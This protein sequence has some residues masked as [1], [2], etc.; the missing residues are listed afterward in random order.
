[1]WL[2]SRNDVAWFACSRGPNEQFSRGDT[3]VRTYG[4][5]RVDPEIFNINSHFQFSLVYFG[6]TDIK[7]RNY[8]AW[9][10]DIIIVGTILESKCIYKSENIQKSALNCFKNYL[11]KQSHLRP[12]GLDNILD[13]S[14]SGR[15]KATIWTDSL[16]AGVWFQFDQLLVCW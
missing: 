14:I 8:M 11:N 7:W 4:K 5:H 15:S 10:N 6:V 9:R 2:A 12:L 3:A 13:E 1:M 16:K